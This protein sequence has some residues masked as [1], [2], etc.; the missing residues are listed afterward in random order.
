MAIN[1]RARRAVGTC[2]VPGR[3]RR[4]DMKRAGTF[5]FALGRHRGI[6]VAIAI[7]MVVATL[8]LA[9]VVSAR[10]PFMFEFTDE[11]TVVAPAGT[12]CDF[13]YHADFVVSYRIK[14][15]F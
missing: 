8:S 14:G 3:H 2:T 10:Q 7:G 6:Q 13:D 1:T 15:F 9:P 12:L 4:T 5:A 11:G